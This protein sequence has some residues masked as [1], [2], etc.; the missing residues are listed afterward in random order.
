MHTERFILGLTLL[1]LL[2]ICSER[3]KADFISDVL[4]ESITGSGQNVRLPPAMS[5]PIGEGEE[6]SPV[7]FKIPGLSI[8]FLEE[9]S[10]NRSDKL[11]IDPFTVTVTSD[12]GGDEVTPDPGEVKRIFSLSATSFTLDAHTNDTISDSINIVL[13]DGTTISK[14][15]KEFGPNGSEVYFSQTFDPMSIVLTDLGDFSDRID[16][17]KITVDFEEAFSGIGGRPGQLQESG[18][19]ATFNYELTFASG[20]PEP[21]TLTLLIIGTIG[22]LGYGRRRRKQASV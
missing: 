6:G 17:G 11:S 18:A 19:G 12:A 22:L 9:N 15:L 8:T 21:S 13:A 3:A 20:T 5:F 7:V 14:Q 4:F 16:I 1:L 2:S 10:G